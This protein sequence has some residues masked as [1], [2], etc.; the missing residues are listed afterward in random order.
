MRVNG[1]LRWRL[2]IGL[3][4]AVLFDTLLQI[5]W[6]SAVLDTPSGQAPLDTIDSVL[7]NPLFPG[8]VAIMTAQFL[9]WLMVLRQ[10]DLSYAKPVASLSYASV[11]LF[12][13]LM[14][15][16][17]VDIVE[18][19]GVVLVVAGV[20]FISRTKPMANVTSKVP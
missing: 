20:C 14:L 2:A 5:I 17:A 16:E 4:A 18:I 6:K 13:A 1:R 7:L 19:A 12:S 3:L 9:N 10:A 11:P 15:N 8:V